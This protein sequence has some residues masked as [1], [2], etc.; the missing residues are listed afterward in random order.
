[1]YSVSNVLFAKELRILVRIPFVHF[2]ETDN[3]DTPTCT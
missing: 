2:N 1:M 3:D